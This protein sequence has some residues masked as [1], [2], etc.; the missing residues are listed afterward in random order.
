MSE[1][2]VRCDVALETSWVPEGGL[3]C[4]VMVGAWEW[5]DAVTTGRGHLLHIS[6]PASVLWGVSFPGDDAALSEHFLRPNYIE[7]CPES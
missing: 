4:R 5:R 2:A 1:F 7:L 3:P 6:D